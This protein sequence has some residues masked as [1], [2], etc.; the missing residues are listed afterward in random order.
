MDQTTKITQLQ[1]EVDALREENLRLRMTIVSLGN[2]TCGT[3]PDDL[4]EY[5]GLDFSGCRFG[6][7]IVYHTSCTE[8]PLT[9]ESIPHLEMPFRSYVPSINRIIFFSTPQELCCLFATKA[10]MQE[11]LPEFQSAAAAISESIG[12]EIKIALSKL[13]RTLKRIGWLHLE[14]VSVRDHWAAGANAVSSFED[15]NKEPVPKSNTLLPSLEQQL[16]NL[17]LQHSFFDAAS[18]FDHILEIM[19]QDPLM[20]VSRAADTVHIR[21]LQ[22]LGRLGLSLNS[23]SQPAGYADALRQLFT[24]DSFPEIRDRCH[25]FFVLLEDSLNQHAYSQRA[26]A[27]KDYVE[28]HYSEPSLGAAQLCDAFLLSESYLSRIFKNELGT[29]VSDYIHSVRIREAKKLLAESDAPIQDICFRLGYT[30][31]N[32]MHRAFRD[33][34]GMS[35]TQY[36]KFIQK[37]I[38]RIG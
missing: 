29:K 5:S 13:H 36:R 28:Q 4:A 17:V 30:N 2:H 20:T 9:A 34:T 24:V 12:T 23:E 35:P 1:Q 22:L 3:L 14:A 37:N 15:L 31:R 26:Q 6:V 21:L 27:I 8:L 16:S 32:T 33:F 18:V 7:A 38:C 19:I 10:A 25:D 11:L